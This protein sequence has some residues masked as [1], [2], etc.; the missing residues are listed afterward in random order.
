MVVWQLVRLGS[1][2][3]ERHV[4]FVCH[5]I[6][7]IVAQV[8]RVH[9]EKRENAIINR[10]NKTKTEKYPDLRE[11]KEARLKE[12][13]RRDRDAQQA[14]VRAF[15]IPRLNSS[16]HFDSSLRCSLLFACAF[17]HTASRR[18]RL[19]PQLQCFHP[20]CTNPK[21]TVPSARKKRESLR[22]GKSSHG[23]GIMP[24]TIS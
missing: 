19:A 17:P 1:R 24:T 3:S 22:R 21:L 8:K 13:G 7:L 4:E 15:L 10:L 20:T 16:F 23:G 14:R 12:L 11:E 5:L 18:L 6:L 2:I 9:V